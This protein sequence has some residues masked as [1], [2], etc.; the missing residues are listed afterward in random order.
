[1]ASGRRPATDQTAARN[2]EAGRGVDEAAAAELATATRGLVA[3]F[4]PP[5][6]D[7]ADGR[8]AWE[9]ESY[10]FL[11]AE[12]PDTARPALWHQ[13]RL[14]R[15]AGLFELTAG[16]YQLRG[17][18]LSNMHVIEGEEGIVVVDPL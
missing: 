7:R 15:V 8:R 3:G 11:D 9:L 16:V 17:F 6:V 12:P 10:A 18:D 1:M 2:R 14:N 4:E 5:V 13:A